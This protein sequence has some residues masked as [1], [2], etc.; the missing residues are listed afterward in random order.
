MNKEIEKYIWYYLGVYVVVLLT[1][2][3]FQYFGECEGASLNCK[4][5]WEKVKDILQTTAY[6]LTP[7]VAIIALLSWKAQ[8]NKLMFSEDAKPIL[9]MVNNDIK[10]ITNI[11]GVLRTKDLNSRILRDDF[12]L[13]II[14]NTQNLLNNSHE[15]SSKAFVLYGLTEDEKLEEKRQE[16]H[17]Y[18]THHAILIN[19]IIASNNPK[20][21]YGYL[22]KFYD[23]NMFKFLE[24]NKQYK[25][26]LREFILA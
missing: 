20:V 24:I 9:L 15:I 1:F 12:L 19:K 26:K 23:T 25:K 7:I 3:A 16:Y 18:I 17:N 5:N 10:F 22:L 14:D 2:T 21:T 4:T 8:H 13:E 6:I 11:S